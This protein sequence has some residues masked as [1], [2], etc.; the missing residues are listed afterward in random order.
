MNGHLATFSKIKNSVMQIKNTDHLC[1][2]RSIVRAISC[3]HKNDNE[4]NKK[5]IL[6]N[7]M[8]KSVQEKKTL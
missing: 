8:K 5:T 7:A 2:P 3:L 1:L 4:K 6:Q